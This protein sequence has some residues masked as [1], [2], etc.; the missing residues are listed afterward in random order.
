MKKTSYIIVIALTA[1]VCNFFWNTSDLN[2][3]KAEAIN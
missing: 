3:D 2:K 1:L